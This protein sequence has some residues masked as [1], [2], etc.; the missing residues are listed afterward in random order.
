MKAAWLYIVSMEG[1]DRQENLDYSFGASSGPFVTGYLQNTEMLLR[2]PF[3]SFGLSWV[4]SLAESS[5]SGLAAEQ[6]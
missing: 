1:E 3:M 2:S 5:F 6:C 4:C